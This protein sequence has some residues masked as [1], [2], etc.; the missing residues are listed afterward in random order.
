MHK[1]GVGTNHCHSA[2]KRSAVIPR[3]AQINRK[4]TQGEVRRTDTGQRREFGR[5]WNCWLVSA[6]MGEQLAAARGENK[7]ANGVQNGGQN[8]NDWMVCE[9]DWST[10]GQLLVKILIISRVRSICYS[11]G[12]SCRSSWW[13]PNISTSRLIIPTASPVRMRKANGK[14][15]VLSQLKPV[16]NDLKLVLINGN[17]RW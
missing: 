17:R 2:A 6:H 11:F 16:S 1:L 3:Q 4:L 12:C 7:Q 10:A 14:T 9:A 5:T 15:C 13:S 8:G